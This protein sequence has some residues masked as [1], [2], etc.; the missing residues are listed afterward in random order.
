MLI[1]CKTCH[2][3][4]D[5]QGMSPGE[6][7]RCRCGVLVEVPRARPREA[8][9]LHCSGCGGKLEEKAR[10]CGYCGAEI[11]AAERNLGP[12]CPEC[13]ARMAAGA[14]F[15]AECGVAIRP[16][17]IKATR[18]SARCPRCAGELVLQELVEGHFTECA[19]CGGIWLDAASFERVLER[20]DTGAIA[21]AVRAFTSEKGAGKVEVQA[22][23]YVPCPVCAG[24]MNRK[25]FGGCSGVI[26]DWCKGHGFWFDAYELEK[27][28]QFI[29][30]GGLDKARQK[31]IESAR[32]EIEMLRD[33]KAHA[34]CGASTAWTSPSRS[35]PDLYVTLI[36]ELLRNTV[37]AKRGLERAEARRPRA[38]EA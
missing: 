5:V 16:E 34:S 25:N 23:K 17:S 29:N 10:K 38:S 4:F 9:A 26:I 6:H 24:M 14:K 35:R 18:A 2:R 28:V 1:A 37:F 11:T 32:R 22:V 12:A 7:V 3:Q 8:R 33:K 31:E 19:S 30:T 20:K 27:V 15:C 36:F 21:G 13:F